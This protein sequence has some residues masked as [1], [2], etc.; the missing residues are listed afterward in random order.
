MYQIKTSAYSS[1]KVQRFFMP[2]N[3]NTARGQI[4]IEVI[5]A[6]G[7]IPVRDADVRIYY[8]LDPE[9]VLEEV[10]TDENG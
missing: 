9:N 4:I 3:I 10:K 5:S 7:L 2:E 8:T 6:L 1:R